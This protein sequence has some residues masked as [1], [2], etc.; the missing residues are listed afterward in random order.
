MSTNEL[1][2]TFKDDED[3]QGAGFSY[4]LPATATI[5]TVEIKVSDLVLDSWASTNRTLDINNVFEF[6]IG[7]TENVVGEFTIYQFNAL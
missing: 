3:D 6:T 4:H 5:K 2:F 7:I 1:R